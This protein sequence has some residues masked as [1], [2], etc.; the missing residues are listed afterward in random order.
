MKDLLGGNR[1]LDTASQTAA[2]VTN[3]VA[4]AHDRAAA[5]AERRAKAEKKVSDAMAS[6]GSLDDRL[7]AELY[8][9]TGQDPLEAAIEAQYEREKAAGVIGAEEVKERRKE[10]LAG[11]R[12]LEGI[13]K[14]KADTEKIAGSLVDVALDVDTAP[15]SEAEKKLAK[16]MHDL[17][18]EIPA[19]LDLAAAAAGKYAQAAAG[20]ELGKRKD[21]I[22]AAAG[23]VL[24]LQE[25]TAQRQDAEKDAAAIAAEFRTPLENA[26]EKMKE[27]GRSVGA[28][29]L[30][31]RFIALAAQQQG[32]QLAQQ[33][34]GEIQGPDL[35]VAGS[36]EA[37]Q[38]LVRHEQ[39]S[40]QDL[41]R[42]AQEQIRILLE[43]A[44]STRKEAEKEN[45]PPVEDDV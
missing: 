43:I 35:A 24:G 18:R 11:I 25:K 32:A 39:G 22:I 33:F 16:I 19:D 20:D 38:A 17:G 26:T 29:A 27:I 40:A 13:E 34:S 23:G 5:A 37:Y 41:A 6:S 14:D 9:A 44:Q 42:K 7:R 45:P 30:D 28:G 1:E 21:S 8:G 4:E 3:K 31:E 10:Q 36:R 12:N 15:L 2:E